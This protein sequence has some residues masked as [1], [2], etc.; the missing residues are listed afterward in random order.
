MNK[1][2]ESVPQPQQLHNQHYE[3][4]KQAFYALSFSSYARSLDPPA[5]SPARTLF[6]TR[7]FISA[8]K[9]KSITTM[10]CLIKHKELKVIA[11]GL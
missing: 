8:E 11:Y 7:L 4:T 5:L 2:R 6:N 3:V 10:G 1:M 9:K